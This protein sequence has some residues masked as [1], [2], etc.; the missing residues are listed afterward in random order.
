MADEEAAFAAKSVTIPAPPEDGLG[1]L[2]PPDGFEWAYCPAKKRGM[3]INGE[4]PPAA[5]G[6]G[7]EQDG[8]P[9][10]A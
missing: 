1:T 3:I 5:A 2:P 6:A 4:K 10:L 8:Q 7:M 9:P